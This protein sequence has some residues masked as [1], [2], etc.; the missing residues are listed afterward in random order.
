MIKIINL[1]SR[2]INKPGLRQ[3]QSD[4]IAVKLIGLNESLRRERSR[5]LNGIF[6]Y[7]SQVAGNKIHKNLRQAQDPRLTC[8]QEFD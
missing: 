1:G 8:R 5:H 3:D 7:A 2:N 4:L 6:L